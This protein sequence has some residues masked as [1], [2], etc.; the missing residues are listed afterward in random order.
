[1][2]EKI[3]QLAQNAG[4]IYDPQ[5][6]IHVFNREKFAQLVVR[7]CCDIFVELRTRPAALVVKDVKKHFGIE[8]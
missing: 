5:E 4:S 8:E 1:M 6:G 3:K 2:N 7:E